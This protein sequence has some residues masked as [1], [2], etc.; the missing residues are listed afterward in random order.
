MAADLFKGCLCRYGTSNL[1]DLIYFSRFACS[2]CKYW[3]CY[4]FRITM[5]ERKTRIRRKKRKEKRKN[6]MLLICHLSKVLVCWCIHTLSYF[7]C[8]FQVG[9]LFFPL[10]SQSA[11]C[12]LMSTEQLISGVFL[13]MSITFH[14]K[15]NYRTNS[16]LS[17]SVSV[18]G[19]Q[20]P[21][22]Y[23]N[24]LPAGQAPPPPVVC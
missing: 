11:N 15:C 21:G 1:S 22:G 5:T 4:V 2:L 9:F 10:T 7:I 3:H 23:V 13:N 24:R 17:E 8:R 18:I 6:K 16:R 19:L 20:Q 14:Y 12:Q